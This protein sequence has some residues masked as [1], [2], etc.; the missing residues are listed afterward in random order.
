MPSR[1]GSL[2]RA[3]TSTQRSVPRPPV[4]WRRTGFK[5]P[6]EGASANGGHNDLRP[7]EEHHPAPDVAISA[8]QRALRHVFRVRRG[9][10]QLPPGRQ[11]ASIVVVLGLNIPP[12]EHQPTV[13]TQARSSINIQPASSTP[14]QAHHPAPDVAISTALLRELLPHPPMPSLKVL[15]AERQERP[16]QLD[17]VL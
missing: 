9:S 7:P 12:E 2:P 14:P 15:P 13:V 6:S 10:K 11:V 8:P 16:S 5:D 1:L 4:H 17:R 3:P